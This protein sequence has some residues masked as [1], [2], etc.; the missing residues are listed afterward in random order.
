MDNLIF[1]VT[2][3]FIGERIDKYLSMQIQGKSRSFIQ[4]LITDKKIDINGSEIKSNY[5][6]RKND[7]I[8]VILPEPIELNVTAEKID[9][10]IIYE[11]DRFTVILD[12]SPATKG[13]ALILPKNHAANIYELPDEDASAVFVLAKKLATK[14]TEILHCDGFNIVQNNGEVAGQTVFHFHMHL[15]PRYLNDGNQDKLTWNHAEFTPE[16]IAEI[17]AELRA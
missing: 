7:I 6:L 13:H 5:K 17:A 11:D 8:N 9:I 12:A 2:D 14:M 10:N 1:N 15:I 16:E 3:E 4:G